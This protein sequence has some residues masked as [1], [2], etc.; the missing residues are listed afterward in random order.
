MSTSP[1]K[2]KTHT[3]DEFSQE[4]F[5]PKSI[6]RFLVDGTWTPAFA[7][8]NDRLSMRVVSS[9][10]RVH[11][12][13]CA[14]AKED[15][16]KLCIWL[17]FELKGCG[18]PK[19]FHIE[20]LFPMSSVEVLQEDLAP[21]AAQRVAHAIGDALAKQLALMP[22]EVLASTCMLPM[23]MYEPILDALLSPVHDDTL[24][25][26]VQR[27]LP[28]MLE[29]QGEPFLKYERDGHVVNVR[30]TECRVQHGLRTPNALKILTQISWSVEGD[31]DRQGC[32]RSR[33]FLFDP[34]PAL[35]QRPAPTNDECLARL[36]QWRARL[37]RVLEQT[38]ISGFAP[39]RLKQLLAG[40]PFELM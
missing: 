7:F 17:D 37:R 8:S 27:A 13:C 20:D 16:Q 39:I 5:G 3:S 19:P 33:G 23:R 32:W 30:I 40:A 29:N 26:F 4:V 36:G 28:T 22:L 10:I 1:T 15:I 24:A 21:D 14:D 6:G 35:M 12:Q 38:T 9:G 31:L 2:I 25:A 34:T 11:Q 18:K